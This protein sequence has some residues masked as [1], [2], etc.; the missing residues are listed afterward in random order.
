MGVLLHSLVVVVQNA[1]GPLRIGRASSL[2]LFMRTLG[3]SIGVWALGL[4]IASEAGGLT[5]GA[6]MANAIGDAYRMIQSGLTDVM[7]TGGSEAALTNMGMGGFAAMRALST[8][9]DE[10]TRAS[11]PFDQDRDGFVLSDHG[12]HMVARRARIR[13]IDG[14]KPF[15]V[16][17]IQRCLN[18]V[19]AAPPV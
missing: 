5:E 19:H 18:F 6:T 2:A 4:L 7:I 11:R 9:N 10:P 17:C 16:Q 15:F 8:R 13:R 12:K 3:G 14:V 1:A